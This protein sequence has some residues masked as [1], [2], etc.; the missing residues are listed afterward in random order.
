MCNFK[1][2]NSFLNPEM[3]KS[4]AK[5]TGYNIMI[6]HFCI[7]RKLDVIDANVIPNFSVFFQYG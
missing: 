3:P 6:V 5:K 1:I 2:E 4:R 7:R